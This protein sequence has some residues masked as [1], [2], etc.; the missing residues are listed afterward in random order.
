[1]IN[2]VRYVGPDDFETRKVD[3]GEP[4]R[5]EIDYDAVKELRTL[6]V[7]VTIFR[8]DGVRCIDAP[9]YTA[10]ENM[11]IP[12]GTG[13]LVLDFPVFSLQAGRYDMTVAMYDPR[14]KRYYQLHQRLYP[15]TVRDARSTGGV[16]WI[17]YRWK[18]RG[19]EAM[20]QGRDGAESIA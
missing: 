18:L 16:V 12:G 10:R 4:L 1:V 14:G 3:S 15:F 5:V 6:E 11:S 13:T 20:G 8:N 19:T 9:L 7:G 17:D 2:A